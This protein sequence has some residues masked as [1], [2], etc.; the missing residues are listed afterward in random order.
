MVGVF[1]DAEFRAHGF[2]RDA[3]GDLVVFD[4]PDSIETA[5]NDLNDI[6]QVTG[7]FFD[8]R[9]FVHGF[10]RGPDAGVVTVEVPGKPE[11]QSQGINNLGQ[12]AGDLATTPAFIATPLAT[13]LPSSLVLLV[14]TMGGRS[15]ATSRSRRG[16]AKA[17][18]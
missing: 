12:L 16:P 13:P 8:T 4:V 3:D 9:G 14:V 1:T 18:A 6:G 15:V 5:P 10:V 7:T 11:T 2:L 17:T